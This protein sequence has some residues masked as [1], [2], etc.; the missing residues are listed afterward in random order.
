MSAGSLSAG[1]AKARRRPLSR[2]RRERPPLWRRLVDGDGSRFLRLLVAMFLVLLLMLQFR[3]W[4]GDG[5]VSELLR[6][7]AEVSL[8]QQENDRLRERNEALD[9][10]VIDLKQGEAAVEERAR[11]ELGMIREGETFFQAAGE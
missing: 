9:A 8:Q 5:G 2:Q 10:E 7:K 11:R 4:F 1:R 6:L 3:L